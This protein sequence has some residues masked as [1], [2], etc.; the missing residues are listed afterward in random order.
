MADGGRLLLLSAASREAL[1]EALAQAR[2]GAAPVSDPRHGW[3]LAVVAE[4]D[5]DLLDALTLAERRLAKDDKPRF[6]LANRVFMGEVAEDPAARR[7]LLLFP[8]FGAQHPS[9]VRDLIAHFPAVQAWFEE[10]P[11]AARR[12]LT[13][14][15][16]LFGA[17][18]ER[19]PR[20]ADTL[21][22]VLVAD[23]AMYRLLETHLPGLQ[24]QGMLG[25]SY[26]DTALLSASGMVP[27]TLAILS[28]LDRMLAAIQ[29][30][31]PQALRRAADTSMLAVTAVSRGTL[32]AFRQQDEG[33]I[34]LALDNCPQQAI[35]CGPRALMEALEGRLR[36]QGHLCFRLPDLSIPVHTP[37][38]PVAEGELQRLYAALPLVDPGLPVYSCETPGPFP[39]EPAALQKQLVHQ[40]TRPVRFRQSITRLHEEGYR[41]FL[42]VGPGGHL[43]GFVR[44]SLRGKEML[45]L[46]TNLENR[47]SL[48]QLRACVAQLYVAG[49]LLDAAP[50][51][52]RGA[53]GPPQVRKPATWPVE[54]SPTMEQR[55][56]RLVADLLDIDDPGL[57]DA[58]QG[59]F[60]LGMDSLQAVDL[61]ERLQVEMNRP[62]PQT[63]AFDYPDIRA[64]AR[65]LTGGSP[66]IAPLGGDAQGSEI[67]IIGMGCRFPGEVQTPEV[68]WRLLEEGRDAIRPLPEGRWDLEALAAAGISIESMPQILAGGFLAEVR[69]FDAAF[70]GISPREALAM[71]PQQRLL[72]EVS[73][74]A[75]EDADL[76]PFR[77]RGS[78]TGIFVGISSADYA[79]RL[80]MVERLRI[81]GYLGTG[82][83]QSTAAGRLSFL[84]GFQGPCM[85]VDTAC[86]SSLV[87]VHL[88][89]RSLR[90]GE[91]GLALA[92]GVNLML[93]PETSIF[94]ARA[95]ALAPD[96]RCKTFDEAADGY[97]RS[98]G[99]GMVVLKRLADAKT[100]GDRIWAVIR[101]SAINH[102]GR[103]SG[104]TV[105]NGR[106]QQTVIRQAMADAGVTPDQLSFLETHGTGTQLGDPIEVHALGELFG[107][108]PRSHPLFLGAVKSNIGH[109]EAAA[110]IAG[111]IKSALQLA[112][113]RLLPGLHLRHPSSRVTWDRIPLQVVT[114]AR[115]WPKGHP[116]VAGLSSFG[117]SGTNAHLVLSEPPPGLGRTT[118]ARRLHLLSL[119]AHSAVAAQDLA[120]LTARELNDDSDWG[121]LCVTAHRGRDH[122]RHRLAV[123]AADA[124]EARQ[125]LGQAQPQASRRPKLAFLFSGQGSQYPGMGEGLYQELP[126]FRRALEECQ[127]ALRPHLG[128]DISDVLWGEVGDLDATGYTQ[129]A[130]FALEYALSRLWQH[131]G[132]QPDYVLGHSIGEFAAACLAGVM[133]LDAGVRLV[134]ARGRLMQALPAGGGMLA[135]PLQAD[136]VEQLLRDCGLPLWLA[137]INTKSQCVLSGREADLQRLR[138]LLAEQG[139]QTTPVRVSHA[140]HSGLM[141]PMVPEFDAL[142][143]GLS[144]R[145]PQ[146]SW[147]STLTGEPLQGP[148]GAD[149]WREQLLRPVRFTDAMARL[150]KLGADLFVEIGPRPVLTTMARHEDSRG[151]WV[152]SLQPGGDEL[153]Q[154]LQALAGLYEAGLNPDWE[155]FD[156]GYP[157]RHSP[158]PFTPFE[159][160]RLWIEPAA[161]SAS[162]PPPPPPAPTPQSTEAARP[163]SL[164]ARLRA[165]PEEERG[166]AM[167]QALRRMLASVLGGARPEAL[168][169]TLSLNQQGLDSLMAM[170]LRNELLSELGLDV[171]LPQLTGD[172]SLESL[173]GKALAQ[174]FSAERKAP[175]P[176]ADTSAPAEAYP[177]SYGQRALWFLWRLSPETSAYSLSLP[178]KIAPGGD[179]Q[180]WRRGCQALVAMHPMLRTHFF[181]QDGEPRQRALP[182][183]DIDWRQL[184]AGEWH[185]RDVEAAH[186]FPFDLAEGPVIRFRWFANGEG[187]AEGGALLLISMHHIV[188]DG[189]S[190]ELIRRQLPRLVAGE[191][192]PLAEG[193]RD[194]VTG[195]MD[196]LQ[197]P[198]GEG[199]WQD[200]RKLL[201]GEL[202]LLD[203]PT[204]FPRPPVK[205]LTGGGIPFILPADV[206]KRLKA[207]A[208]EQEATPYVAFL[209]LFLTLLH[210]YS[211][212]DDLLVGSPQAGRHRPEFTT[213]VGYFVDPLVLRSRLPEGRNFRGFVTDTRN[214][215]LQ[216]LELASYPFALL[217]ER[218]S[219]ARDP[220]RS[221]LF[222]VSFNF[223]AAMGDTDH[224]PPALAEL[225]QADGKFDLSLNLQ[226]GEPVRGWFGYDRSLFR[227]E[228]LERLRDAFIALGEAVT[229]S[230]DRPL[231]E[232]PWHPHKHWL[233]LMQGRSL[234]LG[235][236]A[237]IHQ[238]VAALAESAG[239][240]VAMVAADATLSY[241]QLWNRA[242]SLTAWLQHRGLGPGD[243][244][245]VPARRRSSLIIAILGIW[246]AGAAYVPLDPG[247]P[248]PLLEATRQ[249]N[250]IALMLD[251]QTLA[252]A[253]SEPVTENAPLP[254]D[255]ER[256]AY[257]I[258]TSGS[259]GTP[260]GVAVSQRALTNYLL[261]ISEA[262]DIS[263]CHHFAL[264]SSPAADLGLT[265]VFL[266]LATGGCLHLLPEDQ[267]LD[268][269]A[270]AHYMQSHCIDYLKIA[271]SHF[272]ALSSHRPAMPRKALILGGEAASPSWAAELAKTAP[273]CRIF[274]HYGPTEAT[275]GVL[276][277]AFDPQSSPP[278]ASLPLDRVLA[279]TRIYLLDT[280]GLPVLPGAV[281][282]IHIAGDCLAEGYVN[283]PRQ[284]EDS[285]LERTGTRV[286]RTGDL[287][288]Q[289]ADGGLEILGRRDRQLKIRGY[290]VEPGQ[291]EAVLARQAGVHQCIVLADRGGRLL[292]F[293]RWARER[294][295]E[296]YLQQQLAMGLP[297]HMV[298]DRVFLLDELPRAGSGK[299]DTQALL[300][301]AEEVD[302]TDAPRNQP[303][304]ALE[305]ELL[306]LWQEVLEVPR[307]GIDEDFFQ[308]GGHSLLAIRLL[309]CIRHRFGRAISLANLLT[310]ASVAAMAALLRQQGTAE[311]ARPLV[312]LT[313]GGERPPLVLLPGAGGSVVYLLP[314]A[315]QVTL[316]SCWAF[317]ALGHEQRQPIPESVEAIAAHYVELLLDALPQG[318]WH[319]AGHS[320][321]ALVAYEMARI[322]AAR[323]T[324]AAFLGLL[325]NPAPD[326][327]QAPPQRDEL[328]WLR[329]IAIRIAKMT[330]LPVDVA[331]LTQGEDYQ[332]AL[333][334]LVDRLVEAGL[335][336]GDVDAGRFARFIEIYKANAMA[337]AR[338]RPAPLKDVNRV[339]VFSATETDHE[340]TSAT[341][342]ADPSLG[343]ARLLPEPPVIERVPGTHLS[344]FIEPQVATLAQRLWAWLDTG[345]GAPRPH[346]C[347]GYGRVA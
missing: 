157:W 84:Y 241:R 136:Q 316:R 203:L 48:S 281:G 3:R 133:D 186:A 268:G 78:D 207:L 236:E 304:D 197:G 269:A 337:A 6:N 160:Q 10:L 18:E 87:A 314:L 124:Q 245:G 199:L 134:A 121:D 338:Y 201:S 317:Q 64:L 343:W 41:T 53:S 225:A 83:A 71:D 161:P 248:A 35:L 46:A 293:A 301:L 249:R 213:V 63:L 67:A 42:E 72:L 290:R 238:R 20:F 158:L 47:P 328:G 189:W 93:S 131:W 321:G 227:P 155:A 75:L 138:R 202:P 56:R 24:V 222:D 181:M 168:D 44:D 40:W 176:R 154:V 151:T 146:I 191:H 226:D 228:T 70:F 187:G 185:P 335:L 311:I 37:L 179:P 66:D 322:L 135:V 59:F 308:L 246:G 223:T 247:W 215:V 170:G 224:G 165:C 32:E 289:R 256:L 182:V 339:V 307:L 327:T 216:S 172:E 259:T 315:R 291:I 243:L 218:L 206:G 220:S 115:D 274:N 145:A 114:Q 221:P 275:I 141:E 122:R 150:R 244:V 283:A 50:F 272:A 86:S 318:P 126:P 132:I 118:P 313:R 97:V 68:Y 340:L 5:E 279:N 250:D 295:G 69:D 22:A 286:Y 123:V 28:F 43:T 99:C 344:M 57:L 255:L 85:A 267:V 261:S 167:D 110:G 299:P 29:T 262:L 240:A 34:L 258:F 188:S 342:D 212:Q 33:P 333:G 107:A 25:H 15:P 166:P 82:N 229:R 129:P 116:R 144:G 89:C 196:L 137:A 119:S 111:L 235:G 27:D 13:T 177:L 92:G 288:R 142:T 81:G 284:T 231:W 264:V 61:V 183:V 204:D 49:H 39:R 2:S 12:R 298:P 105:P 276:I 214:L 254:G 237:L 305:V 17:T 234:P 296:T 117:I 52:G 19:P 306:G 164:L 211:G 346:R 77:L 330:A 285:F 73:H 79:Q 23:L 273:Q 94:L 101:G 153:R 190:L 76:A 347:V 210:R 8:G 36:A 297:P 58:D 125:A 253:C 341:S 21:E 55:V 31:D 102:D 292:A 180:A 194:F 173:T 200:W 233:P 326:P 38:F 108:T 324:P 148:P 334:R 147:V 149:Y 14:N 232:L 62:L 323:G 270:F 239:D 130:L 1:Q 193:Y 278:G 30:A 120:A 9:L 310:H 159:R 103:T 91:C 300:R 152:A 195:Q 209:S 74:E 106:A 309:E 156:A 90:S 45:A 294:P 303:R 113:G 162:P 319:L 266:A 95:G 54:D 98:E 88:A 175:V 242:R 109:L 332:G 217:V 80:S 260:K 11:E 51:Q 230:P 280:H 208:R 257:V 143:Q 169:P 320:F 345:E 219:P 325:D 336:P 127:A 60:T 178:L 26:G 282:E 128:L 171:S 302:S 277:G 205:S 4:R 112:R 192:L 263:G 312:P 252:R 139:L 331:A 271:P 16:L 184:K 174:V 65:Y 287:A 251:D 7:T 163:T 140:F 104:F 265:M 96:S 100:D 329:H 198:S